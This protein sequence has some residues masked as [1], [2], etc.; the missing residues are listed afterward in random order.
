M[1]FEDELMRLRQEQ[2]LKEAEDS[3][4][5]AQLT[6]R[7]S[8]RGSVYALAFAWLGIRLCR[9]GTLLQ[10]RFEVAET[11][12]TSQSMDNRIKV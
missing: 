12:S 3:R 7:S 5:I 9:W 4:L 1:F 8:R 10:E 11:A 6:G 2:L